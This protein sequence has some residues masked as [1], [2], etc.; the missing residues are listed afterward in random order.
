MKLKFLLVGSGGREASFASRLAKDSV[1]HAAMGHENPTIMRHVRGTGGSYAICDAD[2]PGTVLEFAS[3]CGVD[4]AFVSAD[5]PL[6][7]GVVDELAKGGVRTIGA[8][9]AAARIEWDKVYSIGVTSEVAPGM[10][11][12]YIAADTVGGAEAAVAEF[13]SRG[14]GIAV[15]P[16]GLTGG[17]GV[18]VMPEHL[19]SYSECVRYAGEIVG[20][21]EQ[22]LFVERLDGIEFTIMGIT[23]GTHLVMAPPTYDYP[24]R[25]EGDRGA[26]TGGMGCFTGTGGMLPFLGPDDIEECR[27]AM[28]GVIDVMR[29]R[30]TPFSGV[31]NGGFFKTKYGIKFMEWNARFGDPEGINVLSLLQ[32]PLSGMLVAMHEGR[33]G[34][35]SFSGRASVT[36]YLVAAEYPDSSPQALEFEVDEGAVSQAGVETYFASCVGAGGSRFETLKKSRVVAFGA[37]SDS[38]EGA[39][40][41]VDAAIDRHVAGGLEFRRDVG[42]KASLDRLA[43]A[44]AAMQ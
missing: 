1:V 18:K 42:S 35:V 31:L 36:K 34:A 10:V 27:R 16:Q 40:S 41:A 13:K 23:D 39:S 6:A 33:L 19:G 30:G 21:G 17:K 22:V 25:H 11:P 28:Q 2:D 5:Q 44:S 3:K 14:M 7:N 24:F 32:T 26:G 9:K 12:F 37:V 8:T 43:A 29:A 20:R 38:V 4:Y 15:K